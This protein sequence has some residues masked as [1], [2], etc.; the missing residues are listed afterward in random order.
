MPK[1]F[2]V[3]AAADSHTSA[4]NAA[5]LR[6]YATIKYGDVMRKKYLALVVLLACSVANAAGPRIGLEYER[7]KDRRSGMTSNAFTV[8][9]GW[10]F[11]KDSLINLVELSVERSRD[12]EADS[13]GFR[14][15]ETKVFLRLRHNRMLN[16]LVGYYLRGGVGRSFNNERDFSYAYIEPGLKFEF[17]DRWEWTVGLRQIDSIDGTSGQRVRKFI[18][19]PSFNLDKNNEFELRYVKG[20]GDKDVRSWQVGYTYRF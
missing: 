11:E 7:E 1:R 19:G 14:E 15:R 6:A 18:T 10:E 13:T 9:T 3:Y 2:S 8:E 17:N 5:S 16:D 20:H 4:A 12:A